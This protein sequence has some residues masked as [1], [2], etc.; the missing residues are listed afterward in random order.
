M[1]LQRDIQV[2]TAGSVLGLQS[3][4]VEQLPESLLSNGLIEKLGAR[5][6]VT[7]IPLLNHLRNDKR[8]KENHVLNSQ[9][10][11][12]FSLSLH[13]VLLE[14]IDTGRFPLVLGGDCS[15]LIGILSAYKTKGNYG[16]LFM[17]AHADFYEPEK[18]NTGEAADMDLAIVTGR[19]P[20]LLSNI[21]G[22][23]PYVPDKHVIHI[24]QRDWEETKQYGSQDIKDTMI[25]C[26]DLQTIR[27]QGTEKVI[28]SIVPAI[29]SANVDG[30]WIHFD[31]DVLSDDIN[32]AVD[33]RLPDGLAFRETE[34]FL[35]SFISTGKIAGMSV[36]IFNPSLDTDGSIGKNIT[37]CIV[38]SLT[39]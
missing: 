10:L 3:D 35:Q 38:A 19:G 23:R 4:G 8:D 20:D 5:N 9:P 34:E 21:N 6:E 16:L 1:N 7:R 18:S 14:I 31:T 11:H 25:Q 26:Y 39:R 27:R 30:L 36:T 12:D 29:L 2:I 37:D 28:S 33:Y 15:I 22:L 24:G 32:P 13:N 17:D